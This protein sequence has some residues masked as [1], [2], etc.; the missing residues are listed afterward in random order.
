MMTEACRESERDTLYIPMN[1]TAGRGRALQI[2]VGKKS[3]GTVGVT[4]N[5]TREDTEARDLA[6]MTR[7]RNRDGGRRE[8]LGLMN[9]PGADLNPNQI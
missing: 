6:M 7:T 4:E 9:L 8:C 3:H 5:N 1:K 2:M